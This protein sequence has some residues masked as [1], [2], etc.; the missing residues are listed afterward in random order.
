MRLLLMF[1]VLAILY[2]CWQGSSPPE[3]TGKQGDVERAKTV[4]PE[5][6]GQQGMPQQAGG[7]IQTALAEPDYV[8][9]L[10]EDMRKDELK[11]MPKTRALLAQRGISFNNAYVSNALCCPSRATIMLGVENAASARG[12]SARVASYLLGNGRLGITET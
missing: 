5:G 10:V 7:N 8:F 1:A 3:R 12:E 2:G 11:Y 9:I 6:V 4:T